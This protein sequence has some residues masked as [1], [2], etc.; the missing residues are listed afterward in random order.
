[1]AQPNTILLN[2]IRNAAKAIQNGAPYMWGHMGSCNCGHIA[3]QLTGLDKGAIH[4]KFLKR[5]GDWSE[6]VEEYCPSSGLP[7]DGLIDLLYNNGLTAADICNL[8]NLAD[9]TV[10]KA[11]PGGHRWLHHNN[12]ADAALYLNTWANVLEQRWADTVDIADAFK[13]PAQKLVTA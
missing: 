5:A 13:N 10:L 2:A 3:Q 1:M 8:E 12:P 11:L 9:P 7:A 4:A 6:Q